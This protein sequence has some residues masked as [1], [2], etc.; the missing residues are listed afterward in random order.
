MTTP[1]QERLRAAIRDVPDFPK[2]GIVFKDITPL[3][4]DPVLFS[5]SVE[6][7]CG[8]CRG[9][10]ASKVVGLDARGFIFGAAVASK[11]GLGFVPVRKTGKLP[12]RTISRQYGLEYGS[13]AFEVHTDGVLPGERVILV[14]DLLATGGSALAALGLMEEL[15]A[16]VAGCHFLV[17]LAFLDGRERLGRVPVSSVISYRE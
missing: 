10:G 12:F 14:D 3:L 6:L 17:E 8:E 16:E 7:L 11:L 5:S 1:V 4:A 2:P 15:G 13:S 9:A